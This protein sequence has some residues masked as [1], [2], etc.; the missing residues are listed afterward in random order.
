MAS[1][2]FRR[3]FLDGEDEDDMNLDIKLVD[4]SSNLLSFSSFPVVIITK[5]VMILI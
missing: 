1:V 5:V 2:K 4:I 3:S